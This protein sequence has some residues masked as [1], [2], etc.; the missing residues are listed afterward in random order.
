MGR[1]YQSFCG[2]GNAPWVRWLV[3]GQRERERERKLSCMSIRK[4]ERRE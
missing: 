2:N 1:D 3:G 4:E